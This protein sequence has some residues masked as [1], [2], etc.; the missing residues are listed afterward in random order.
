[1]AANGRCEM[2]DMGGWIV[3][4]RRAREVA[5]FV[6]N[7][8]LVVAKRQLCRRAAGRMI[9]A[10]IIDKREGFRCRTATALSV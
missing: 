9:A 4:G 7:V 2:V 6:D 3:A 1:V 5:V 8:L 10:M